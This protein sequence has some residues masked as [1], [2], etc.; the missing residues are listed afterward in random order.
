MS[1]QKLDSNTNLPVGLLPHPL[2]SLHSPRYLGA[3][4]GVRRTVVAEKDDEGSH[5]NDESGGQ[6]VLAG[7]TC[8]LVSYLLHGM[9]P[10][11]KEL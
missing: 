9:N 8:R 7:I 11:G 1:H 6:R 3:A 2:Q 10:V 4:C 5:V